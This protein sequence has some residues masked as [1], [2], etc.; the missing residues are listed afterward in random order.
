MDDKLLMYN[1]LKENNELRKELLEASR[2][3]SK[4]RQFEEECRLL[5]AENKRLTRENIQLKEEIRELRH[6]LGQALERIVQLE[7]QINTNSNTSHKP[8]SSDGFRKKPRPVSLRDCSKRPRGGQLGHPGTTLSRST[9]V[10]ETIELNVDRCSN[11]NACLQAQPAVRVI[12][13]QVISFKIHKVVTEYQ[14]D[15]KICTCGIKTTAKFPEI[16]KSSVQ[17]AA[18]V[19]A[20][21]CYLQNQHFIPEKRV[22]QLCQEVFGIPVSTSFIANCNMRLS[23]KLDA[24]YCATENEIKASAVKHLDE[25]GVRVNG[26]LHWLH[27]LSNNS[28]TIYRCSAQRSAMPENLQGIIVHDHFKPYFTLTQVNHALCNAHHLRELKALVEFEKE[29]WASKL[30]NLL[31]LANSLNQAPI[32]RIEKLYDSIIESGLK[33]HKQLQKQDL[34]RDLK[35]RKRRIGHNLLLRLKEYKTNTLLFLHNPEVPFTNNQAEQDIRMMKV[36][37]KVSGGFR[38]ANFAEIFCKIRSYI[39]TCRK[40]GQCILDAL[41]KTLNPAI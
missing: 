9:H 35:I 16:A 4:L 26:K 32:S 15:V 23:Q 28:S 29:K 31:Q 37:Q 30:Q 5:R 18:N 21:V 36:K 27:V 13:R 19:Q 6:R 39:S 20:L 33:Y 10:D 3:N 41:E 2:E 38:S 17:Y 7:K 11:C 24:W 25:T 22:Q 12:K 34:A 1:L 14:A 40:R 8:P